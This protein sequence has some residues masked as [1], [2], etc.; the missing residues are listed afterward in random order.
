M[1]MMVYSDYISWEKWKKMH[2]MKNRI[3][4]RIEQAIGVK[5]DS[6]LKFGEDELP[7]PNLSIRLLWLFA[8]IILLAILLTAL[9][10]LYPIIPHDLFTKSQ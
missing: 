10:K 5:P 1:W 6:E 9:I 4:E 3:D 8:Y 7:Y 2:D